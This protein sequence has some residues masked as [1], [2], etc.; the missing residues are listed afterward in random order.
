VASTQQDNDE[1][2]MEP[3]CYPV[4][5]LTEGRPCELHVKFVNISKKAAVKYVL[6]TT[7]YHCH[8][9]QDG[10]DVVLVDEVTVGYEPLMLDHPAGEDEEITELGEALRT[11]VQWW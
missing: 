10:Y 11:T 2:V 5:D 1:Q 4:D 6:P 7:T 8:P 3:P 9:V